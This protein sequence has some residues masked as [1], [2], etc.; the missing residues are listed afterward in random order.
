MHKSHCSSRR[1]PQVEAKLLK[2]GVV[3]EVVQ[4]HDS[5]DEEAM[6]SR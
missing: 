3:K 2:A 1:L 6:I 5:D 4:K